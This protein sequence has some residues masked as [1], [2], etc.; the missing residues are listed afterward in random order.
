MPSKKKLAFAVVL[1]LIF[2][3]LSLWLIMP[4]EQPKADDDENKLTTKTI[5]GVS[6]TVPQDW[7]IKDGGGTVTPIPVEEYL[8]MKFGKVEDRFK[9][10]ETSI[11]ET[12]SGLEQLT[13]TQVKDLDARINDLDE[14]LKD[15]ER[16]LKQGEARRL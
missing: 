9:K 8:S 7:E 14:R 1:I 4:W 12:K 2:A 3:G 15:L 11:G 5:K 13:S 16:W 6:F 10:V